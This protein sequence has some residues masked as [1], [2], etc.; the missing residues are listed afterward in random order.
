VSSGY[1]QDG[2]PFSGRSPLSRHHSAQAATDAARTRGRR[3]RE[4]LDLLA[5][6]GSQGI[7]DHDASRALGVPLS[8][9]NSI[10]NGL[11]DVIEVAGSTESPY[12]AR[13]ITTW[14]KR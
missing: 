8:S 4:Y 5:R 6:V 14:R 10:R 1:T 7:S 11:G 9:I 2:L 12:G 3:S 13:K